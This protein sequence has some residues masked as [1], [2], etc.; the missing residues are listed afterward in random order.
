M[1]A[2][3]LP[4][5]PNALD[6]R[7][8]SRS[9][10]RLGVRRLFSL[11][12]LERRIVLD[13][14]M[15]FDINSVGLTS[16]PQNLTSVG[17]A[18]YF[19]ADDG[20]HGP[21]IWKTD[22]TGP[23]TSFVV[24]NLQTSKFALPTELTAFNGQLFFEANGDLWRTDGTAGGTQIV[25]DSSSPRCF[26]VFN[27]G[28]YFGES[29]KLWKSDGT[30][31]GTTILKDV[32][33][34]QP[35]VASGQLYFPGYD[36]ANGFE[37]WKSD[38]TVAGTVMAASIVS[39]AGSSHP[40]NLTA[41][42]SKVYF[43][44]S[45][46]TSGD[47]V[48]SYDTTTGNASL[49]ADI[50]PGSYGSNPQ[51]FIPSGTNLY[52]AA[53]SPSN[54]YELWRVDTTNGVTSSIGDIWVSGNDVVSMLDAAGT[55]VYAADGGGVG[56]EL[57][58]IDSSGASVLLADINP[59]GSSNPQWLTYSGGK[60]Y[61]SADDGVSGAELWSYDVTTNTLAPVA[62]VR[63]GSLGSAPEQ[64]MVLGSDIYFTADG[65]P[66]GREL[67]K[68]D[69]IAVALVK[70]IAVGGGTYSSN[71]GVYNSNSPEFLTKFTTLNG[72]LLF[73]ADDGRHGIELW[74]SDGTAG[75]TALT[76]DILSTVSYD[77][78]SG[79][80]APRKIPR[81]SIVSNPVILNGMAYFVA[82]DNYSNHCLWKTDG[83]EAGTV[84]VK[85][86]RL[87]HINGELTVA[88]GKIY[89]SGST[90]SGTG[91]YKS[92]GTTAGTVLVKALLLLPEKL[93]ASGNLLFF[94]GVT[95]AAGLELWKSDGTA[96]G[97][98]MVKD[99]NA[100]TAGSLLSKSITDLNGVV[101]FSAYTQSNGYELWRSDGTSAGTYELKDTFPGSVGGEPSAMV[102]VDGT[103]YFVTRNSIG[104]G[105]LTE[106][107]TSDGTTS[108]T[109]RVAIVGAVVNSFT[110]VGGKV[111]FQCGADLWISDGSAAG[112]LLVKSGLNP[113]NL[114]NVF[115][116]LYFSADDG[117]HGRE[118]WKSDGTAAGT[119]MVQDINVGTGGS[120][121]HTLTEVDGQLYFTASVPQF[122]RELWK[123]DIAYPDATVLSAS[124]NGAATVNVTYQVS[125]SDV[126]TPFGL[127]F[128]RSLDGIIDATDTDLGVVMATDASV[129]VHS[130]SFTIGS[131]I[132][133][134]G[135]GMAEI[136]GDYQILVAPLEDPIA[137]VNLMGAYHAPNGG[138]FV[139]G[140]AGSDSITI[141]TS[142]VNTVVTISGVASY[143]Y[144]TT[145]IAVSGFRVRSHGG[146]DTI[147]GAAS[148]RSLF[149]WGG[150]GSDTLTGSAALNDALIGGTG[151]DVYVFV[152]ATATQTDTLTEL[153][154][155]GVDRLNFSGQA[156]T[157]GITVNLASA[158]TTLAT[159]TSRTLQVPVAG[160][161][162]WFEQVIGGSGND[163]LVGNGSANVL[164][165]GAG[166][167]VLTGGEGDDALTGGE[168]NDALTGGEGDDALTG[169][170][171]NDVYNFGAAVASQSDTV[172]E[173]GNGGID[174]L[175]FT[176]LDAS[177]SIA[178]DLSTAGLNLGG[179]NNRSILVGATGQSFQIENV[180]GGPGLLADRRPSPADPA[181][182]RFPAIRLTI[183]SSAVQAMTRWLVEVV[184]TQSLAVWGSIC[185]WSQPTGPLSL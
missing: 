30:T 94:E 182:I 107:W 140:G 88:N 68:F 162:L 128:Y 156:S 27:G 171:G 72:K 163:T 105:Q 124:A 155:E 25:L 58:G 95:A 145:D 122:G 106:L 134:P 33:I 73:N 13:A 164:I 184:S 174:R 44:A 119:L 74:G 142:G 165:G 141:T 10:R 66:Q 52:F 39:G 159:H 137:S 75:G 56:V 60:L 123:L 45:N 149:V 177:N 16:N 175:D 24:E 35:V 65:G 46:G 53:Y 185:L 132:F 41:I 125:P 96:T 23:G 120:A 127:R 93:V 160:A 4:F 154:N 78:P 181:M 54:G 5:L 111:F 42:G 144:P 180:T 55:L 147:S 138:V 84:L 113:Q 38:G 89:F 90:E 91:L 118:L 104:S 87:G 67:W 157:V 61:F 2:K 158:T 99:I 114:T 148:P 7:R 59:S 115:G 130:Q 31:S 81:D 178:I 183:P 152:A 133:L 170:E 109:V 151:D 102:N 9:N 3:F 26:T 76:K 50:Y 11:E 173:L 22:G 82:R 121:P 100:G 12:I 71:P 57:R 101:V 64:L 112:T 129:G 37:L 97:T 28:L 85:N 29:G 8:R 48:W 108:G 14:S 77:L 83:T 92:D 116:T 18:I 80:V 139:H 161:A 179:H 21:E 131:D 43:N 19:V 36:A 63:A 62:D 40:G 103:L 146:D 135:F 153:A 15:V 117:T 176:S 34:G 49:V 172:I 86:W 136:D 150:A 110:A 166:N 32:S 168:G 79:A 70:D 98:V 143:S 47:E 167:D 20:L 69:G 6:S 1:L 51:N 17:T 169:G 126:S